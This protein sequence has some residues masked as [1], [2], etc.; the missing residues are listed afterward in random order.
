MRISNNVYQLSRYKSTD[1]RKH[2]HQYGILYH[3]PIVGCQNILRP[4]V[5]YG[6]EFISGYIESHAVGARL[7]IH[8]CQ[9]AEIVYVGKNSSRI[10]S[11]LK[12]PKHVI[13]L[14]HYALIKAILYSHLVPVCFA[15][16]A[17]LISPFIPDMALKV[18][19][20][21]GFSLPYPQKLITSC[22]DSCRSQG[23][24]RKLFLQII[25][26][27]YSKRLNSMG[28]RAIFPSGPNLLSFR[29]ISILKYLLAH[30]YKQDIRFA[31]TF[32]PSLLTVK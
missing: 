17:V 8:L 15:Y 19:N 22:F 32:S 7:Q 27:Y 24:S 13:Y 30:V 26:I 21:V 28:R 9:I 10:R 6:I 16:R 1:L 25:T 2:V 11:M 3:V 23:Q 14:V 29:R 20:I 18:L 4:L 12:L 31:H 5:E